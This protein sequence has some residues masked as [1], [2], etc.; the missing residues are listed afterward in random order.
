MD[1]KKIEI[2]INFKY[3]NGEYKK[4]VYSF[5]SEEQFD[6]WFLKQISD[7]KIRKVISIKRKNRKEMK[8]WSDSDIILISNSMIKYGN[9]ENCLIAEMLK[10][11]NRI[12]IN[13][14]AIAFSIEFTLFYDISLSI[15]RQNLLEDK[16][17]RP[18][19]GNK[20]CKYDMPRVEY[21]VKS[22][23][24]KC[25]C[26]WKSSFPKNFLL[27]YKNKLKWVT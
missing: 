22:N 4:Q 2:I 13:K 18:Y 9:S 26:G 14:L 5:S 24:F 12:T 21:N 19:C 25:K 15:I 3:N 10:R 11:G 20:N 1:T 16:T 23:Q 6:E 8:Y 17:Y 7:E 27:I